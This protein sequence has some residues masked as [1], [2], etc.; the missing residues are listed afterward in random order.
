MI[1]VHEQ[2]PSKVS[3]SVY[4]IHNK[5]K[6]ILQKNEDKIIYDF[7]MENWKEVYK[8]NAKLAFEKLKKNVS[9]ETYNNVVTLY[10]QFKNKIK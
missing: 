3:P 8:G 1:A 6:I 10:N 5:N 7:I 9:N 2:D 4:G